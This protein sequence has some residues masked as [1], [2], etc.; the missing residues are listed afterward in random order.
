MLR[1]R[2]SVDRSTESAGAREARPAIAATPA[3][4]APAPVIR[5]RAAAAAVEEAPAA[6]V[7]A[8]GTQTPASAL[9]GPGRA[10]SFEQSDDSHHAENLLS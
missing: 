6:A 8:R 7:K 4:S 5:R 2:S 10:G 3:T 1:R 9:H